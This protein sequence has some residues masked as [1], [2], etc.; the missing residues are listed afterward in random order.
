MHA[1][2]RV[3][4]KQDTETEGH[5]QRCGEVDTQRETDLVT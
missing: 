1:E 3:S 4:W 2:S 5:N